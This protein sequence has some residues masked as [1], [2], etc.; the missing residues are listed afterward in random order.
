VVYVSDRLWLY[1][2]TA[3]QLVESGEY[4]M[5]MVESGMLSCSEL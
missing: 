4:Q 5:G 2:R 1:V 3:G